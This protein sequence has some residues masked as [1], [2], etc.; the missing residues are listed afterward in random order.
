MAG[1]QQLPCASP[2]PNAS[3]AKGLVLFGTCGWSDDSILRCGRFYP[4]W[5]KSAEQRLEFYGTHFPCVEV[6]SSTYAIPRPSVTANWAARVP[7]G[8]AFH[9]KAFGLFCHRQCSF[10]SLPAEVKQA[11][12]QREAGSGLG[13]GG[14]GGVTLSLEQLGPELEAA[15]W[16]AFH[17]CL[18]PVMKAGRMGCVVFQ[19]QLSFKPCPDSRAHVEHCRRRLDPRVPMAVE[20]RNRAWFA[21]PAAAADT[22]RW[23][24]SLA[25]LGGAALVAADE[26]RHETYVSRG[27]YGA[28]AAAAPPM[29]EVL[30]IALEVSD[31]R[32]TYVRLHRR[33]GS[34]ERL[35]RQEEAQ[36]WAQRL[37]SLVPQLSGPAYFLIGTDWE[38]APVVNAGLLAAALPPHMRLDWRAALAAAA[39]GRRGTIHSLFAG[40]GKRAAQ[41]PPAAAVRAPAAAEGASA[42]PL[43]GACGRSGPDEEVEEEADCK[44]RLGTA[45]VPEAP[46]ETDSSNGAGGEGQRG[47]VLWT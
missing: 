34:R 39:A 42:A 13:G 2:L 33:E 41:A 5:V 32:F 29:P 23:L 30:P 38:D 21:G 12:Q 37:A 4:A 24:A 26:L 47:G 45:A 16:G 40:V 14:G 31:P 11:L 17:A 22:A 27:G 8:F 10:S 25:P 15:V 20:F 44:V 43:E 19:F 6:D 46:L 9:F 36:A 3:T 7:A 1:A 18:E 28:A 35:L